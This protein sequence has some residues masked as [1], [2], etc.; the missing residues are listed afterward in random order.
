MRSKRAPLGSARSLGLG[1]HLGRLHENALVLTAG[2]RDISEGRSVATHREVTRHRARAVQ[3]HDILA[4][5][6]ETIE[7]IPVGRGRDEV[8]RVVLLR[9]FERAHCGIELARERFDFSA[10]AVHRVELVV[11]VVGDDSLGQVHPDRSECIGPAFH[12]DAPAIGRIARGV[13]PLAVECLLAPESLQVELVELLHTE[14]ALGGSEYLAREEQSR[15]IRADVL[16][17]RRLR[18]R[19]EAVTRP[20]RIRREV[21]IAAVAVGGPAVGEILVV[22]EFLVLALLLVAHG[23]HHRAGVRKPAVRTKMF[24]VL[25]HAQGGTAVEIGHPQR[26]L[27]VVL[28]GETV[29]VPRPRY[30][31][32]ARR[33]I[34]ALEGAH[35]S[36][37]L[38]IPNLVPLLAIVAGHRGRAQ[39]IGQQLTVVGELEPVDSSRIE[40]LRHLELVSG[41]E[42][43]RDSHAS[44]RRGHLHFRRQGPLLGAQRVMHRAHDDPML[45]PQEFQIDGGRFLVRLVLHLLAIEVD[46]QQMLALEHQLR[47]TVAIDAQIERGQ[48]LI[49]KFGRAPVLGLRG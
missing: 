28:G 24:H 37:V 45:A 7:E 33:P 16:Q 26:G 49:G 18:P 14:W 25:Q 38:G 31:G 5:G 47:G 12:Y 4:L 9:P 6:V 48:T 2:F 44:V 29:P 21:Q 3:L 46:L 27:L 22:L 34:V 32:E 1:L 40:Q 35:Q 11:V 36:S 10:G 15:R 17:A 13:G 42:I 19:G 43:R 39:L 8:Q 20:C 41:G 23:V 30:P